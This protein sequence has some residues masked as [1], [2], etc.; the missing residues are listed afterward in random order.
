MIIG[1]TLTGAIWLY[2]YHVRVKVEYIEYIGGIR[3]N[4]HP[5]EQITEQPWWSV[6]ATVILMVIGGTLAA[7]LLDR[8][9]LHWI[10]RRLPGLPPPP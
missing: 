7:C 5:S 9:R 3:H 1:A 6:Y 2:T 10:R 4:F 8:K